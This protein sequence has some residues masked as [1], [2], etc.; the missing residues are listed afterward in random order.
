MKK[1]VK[2]FIVVLIIGLLAGLAMAWSLLYYR[3]NK[4]DENLSAVKRELS[5]DRLYDSYN[6]ITNL[7]GERGLAGA[8]AQTNSRRV[9]AMVR[10][11]LGLRNVGYAIREGSTLKHDSYLWKN[12]W[13]EKEGLEKKAKPI[14][15]AVSYHPENA[16]EP[17]S[18]AADISMMIEAAT[19]LAGRETQ[20]S[21]RFVFST[22][23][24]LMEPGLEGAEHLLWL[25]SGDDSQ[26]FPKAAQ[27]LQVQVNGKSTI[28]WPKMN[29]SSSFLLLPKH[30]QELIDLLMELAR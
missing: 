25:R 13:V 20:R 24:E 4:E 2:V 18:N 7:P 8:E 5:K 17:L 6:K 15:V 23:S 10:G 1:N 30:G 27:D 21:V 19:V 22:S 14:I 26:P 12:Y 11:S 3:V 16:S 29:E 9:L 28:G